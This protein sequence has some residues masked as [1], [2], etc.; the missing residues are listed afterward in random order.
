MHAH[1]DDAAG[2]RDF[3]GV[4]LPVGGGLEGEGEAVG[5][6]EVFVAVE[7]PGDGTF[8][9]GG[10]FEGEFRSDG[11]GELQLGFGDE[12]GFVGLVGCE[13]EKAVFGGELA[14]AGFP[15]LG[16]R[17]SG[18]GGFDGWGFDFA[19]EVVI[20][21]IVP[22]RGHGAERHAGWREA[23][24]P[25]FELRAES[26]GDLRVFRGEVVLLLAV[27][28]EVVEVFAITTAKE[29]PVSFANR[30]LRHPAPVEGFVRRRFVFAGE[31]REEVHAVQSGRLAPRDELRAFAGRRSFR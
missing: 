4:G 13:D 29:F 25:G 11:T 24:G 10:G 3:E 14:V 26:R 18:G 27:G 21:V 8:A 16:F 5:G 12:G 17:S 20:E 2:G 23:V 1:V 22:R 31:V 30:A 7:T 15:A 19:F 9:G 6:E 28:G